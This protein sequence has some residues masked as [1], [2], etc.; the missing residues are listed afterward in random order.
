VAGCGRLFE[1]TAEQMLTSLS[2]LK[3]LP[4]DTLVYCGHEYTQKNLEFALTLEQHNSKLKQKLERVRALRAQGVSTV[5]STIGEEKETNPF[6][7]WD[8]VEIHQSL[9]RDSLIAGTDAL[10]VFSK[11]RELKDH[12]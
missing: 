12:Y 3:T 5:P 7:R 8:S 6:L 2:K 4:D 1:G 10:T 9:Q 11:V